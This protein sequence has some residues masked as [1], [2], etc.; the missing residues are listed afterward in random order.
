MKYDV[1]CSLYDLDNFENIIDNNLKELDELFSYKDDGFIFSKYSFKGLLGDIYNILLNNY[2]ISKQVGEESIRTIDNDIFV[3]RGVIRDNND[4]IDQINVAINNLESQITS[5]TSELHK[6][7]PKSDE[8]KK[9]A[10]SIKQNICSEIN[11]LNNQIDSYYKRK[12]DIEKINVE[13]DNIE[14]KLSN[15]SQYIRNVLKSYEYCI[16]DLNDLYENFISI[17][18]ELEK[19]IN[20]IK[21]VI[22]RA[23][24]YI[25]NAN[26]KLKVKNSDYSDYEKIQISDIDSLLIMRNNA[27]HL[28]DKLTSRIYDLKLLVENVNSLLIDETTKSSSK[29]IYN[30]IEKIN[31]EKDEITKYSK[32]LYEA[33]IILKEYISL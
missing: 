2:E 31:Y 8:E 1:K 27:N 10:E 21:N 18:K 25:D 9:Q 24:N 13:L 22:T 4:V 6:L 15:R 17:Y 12:S 32:K 14:Y 7:S 29:S 30:M 19:T 16:S 28:C 11:T 20:I 3:I 23:K 5:L 26:S 33:Y